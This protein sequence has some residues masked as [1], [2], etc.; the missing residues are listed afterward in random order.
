MSCTST[1]WGEGKAAA[2][3]RYVKYAARKVIAMSLLTEQGRR[4]TFNLSTN[5]DRLSSENDLLF[6]GEMSNVRAHL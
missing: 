4:R 2:G 6:H 3:T 5:V 1:L